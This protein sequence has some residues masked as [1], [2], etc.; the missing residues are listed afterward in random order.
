LVFMRRS[1]RKNPQG[2]R[3]RIFFRSNGVHERK[4]QVQRT[5]DG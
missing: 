3:Y 4:N 2:Y 1:P 5:V